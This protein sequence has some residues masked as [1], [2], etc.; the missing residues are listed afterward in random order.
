MKT[1]ALEYHGEK[2]Q[3]SSQAGLRAYRQGTRGTESQLGDGML[4]FH[5]VPKIRQF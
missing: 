3:K 5:M 4:I 2:P 1:E